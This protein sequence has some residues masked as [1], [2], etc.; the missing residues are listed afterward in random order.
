MTQAVSHETEDNSTTNHPAFID[1]VQETL[2]FVL[3]C[4]NDS[5]MVSSA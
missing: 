5:D 1:T 3:C 2:H 4:K